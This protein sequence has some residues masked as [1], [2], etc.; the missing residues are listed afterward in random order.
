MTTKYKQIK[1]ELRKKN[2]KDNEFFLRRK[3]Q[4]AK[5]GA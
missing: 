4:R 5:K 3:R 1:E 2:V